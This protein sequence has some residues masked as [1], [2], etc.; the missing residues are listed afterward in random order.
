MRGRR[1]GSHMG[2]VFKAVGSRLI[3][4]SSWKRSSNVIRAAC[5]F[6]AMAATSAPT[7]AAS[8]NLGIVSLNTLIPSASSSP[9]VN[10][11]SI[12]DFTGTSAL[13]P[14]FPATDALAF[15][16]SSLVI[17]SSAGSQTVSLGSLTPGSY[18]PASLQFSAANT[19]TSAVFTATLSSNRFSLSGGA[20]FQPASTQI[21]VGLLPLAGSSLVPDRDFAAIA[22][23]DT[24]NVPEPSTTF[25]SLLGAASAICLGRRYRS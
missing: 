1:T 12:D 25:L 8:V 7:Q 4:E 17:T 21:S 3:A 15:V 14:D 11:F 19:F 22:V 24:S 16:N 2:L 23:S 20:T 5:L 10:T 9:G 6:G 18:T 13:P